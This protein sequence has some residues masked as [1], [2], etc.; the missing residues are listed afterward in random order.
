MRVESGLQADHSDYMRLVASFADEESAKRTHEELVKHMEEL[1]ARADNFTCVGFGQT[2]ESEEAFL[3]WKA[4][5]W[6]PVANQHSTLEVTKKEDGSIQVLAGR[7]SQCWPAFSTRRM[8]QLKR[9]SRMAARQFP[10]LSN[11]SGSRTEQS[12]PTRLPCGT[13]G[14][15]ALSSTRKAK[16]A[17]GCLMADRG[18]SSQPSLSASNTFSGGTAAFGPERTGTATCSSAAA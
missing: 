18:Q 17:L 8:V 13:A 5:K 7:K 15:I 3:K 2:F 16:V 4:E 10:T 1:F 12:I 6:D 14:A 9:G 11:I